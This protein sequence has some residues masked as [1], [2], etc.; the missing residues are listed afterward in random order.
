MDPSDQEAAAGLE[1][2]SFELPLGD[3]RTLAY[4]PYGP[5]QGV[6][7]LYHYGTPGT[8]LLSPQAVGA[9]LRRGVRLLVIASGRA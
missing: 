8:R 6:P 7:V 2:T 3:G 5:D 4:C 1:P 9:A